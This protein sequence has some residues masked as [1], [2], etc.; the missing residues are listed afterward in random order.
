MT[1]KDFE[2]LFPKGLAL[3]LNQALAGASWLTSTDGAAVALA[4]R[5]A[6]LLDVV[7]DTG[8]GIKDVPQLSARYLATLQQLHLTVDSRVT[9]K[10][11]E[12]SDGTDYVGDYLRLINTTVKESK[13][14]VTNGG[15]AS[16]K[17]G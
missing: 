6:E 7:L 12:E 9:A 15:A 10:Q 17:S 11:G 4:L 3:S 2:R 13:P 14:R 16:R 8:E 5:L 1:Q